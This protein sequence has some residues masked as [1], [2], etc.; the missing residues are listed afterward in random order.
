[1]RSPSSVSS[2][3]GGHRSERH[4]GTVTDLELADDGLYAIAQ[5]TPAGERILAENPMLG[6]S[7]RNMENYSRSDGR[8]FPAA[9]QHILGTLDPRIPALGP[10]APV[11]MANGPAVYI[12]LSSSHWAGEP[13]PADD[14][15]TDAELA[16][17]IEAM[18]EAELEAGTGYPLGELAEFDAAFTR[19]WA[20]EAA[21]DATRAE[22]DLHDLI[23][24]ARTD[25]DVISRALDRISAGIYDTSAA[26]ECASPGRAAIDLANDRATISGRAA[27]GELDPFGRCAAR[28]HS[29]GCD[30][31]VSPDSSVEM[32]N[33]GVHDR[34]LAIWALA[35]ADTGPASVWGDA[36]DPADGIA[37]P[38]RTLELAHQLAGSWGLRTD[39][40]TRTVRRISATCWPPPTRVTR[41]PR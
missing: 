3:P 28:Y 30:H 15:L 13:G 31:S 2:S 19:Q 11:D 12:D 7:A 37:I 4:R 24:P 34:V 36:D 16:E 20:A 32:S 33:A 29:L 1:M 39:P 41:T 23:S 26:A 9:I 25:E 38:Q 10:W 22:A 35:T 27:C 8:H 40:G 18:E 14:E 17:L 21:A 6:V 5:V